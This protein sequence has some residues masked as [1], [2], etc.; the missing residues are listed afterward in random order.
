MK[1]AIRERWLRPR[2]LLFA[3]IGSA[4]GLGNVWRFPYMVYE[5]GAAAFLIAY[6]IGLVV[7]GIP[8]MMMEFGMGRRMQSGAPG[9]F[10][11]I[12]KKWEWV[13]WWPVF[14]AFLI[15][16]YY[17]VIMAWSLHYAAAAT[18]MAWGVGEAGALATGNYFFGEVLRLS[19]G[20]GV[21]GSPIWAIVG[22]LA[23]TWLV[24]C[25]IIYKGASVIGRVSQYLMIIAWASLVI[26]FFRG[27]TLVGAVDGLNFYLAP[28][29]SALLEGG[30][31]F[32]A[33]SQIAFTLSLGMAGMFAYG[34]FIARRGDIANSA[35]ITS[36]ADGATAFFAGFAIFSTAGY[37][38]Y[39]M[40][41]GIEEVALSGLGLAFVAY[42]SMVSMLPVAPAFFG[43][44]FFLMFWF[45]GISSAYFL[46]YGGV[47]TPL[48]DK[49]GWSR[50][51]TAIGVCLAC[52]II[53][54]LYTT[55]GGLYWLDIVDRTVAFYVLLLSGV[56]AAIVV[57]WAYGADKLREHINETSDFKVGAWFEWIIK[58]VLP[59]GL[60]FVVIYGGF[61]PD[62]AAPYEGY[63]LWA[64]SM[65]WVILIV[66]L[67]ISFLLQSLKT[68][69]SMTGSQEEKG[70]VS[71]E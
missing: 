34:S 21:L 13:G 42:P 70:E 35:T 47:V 57:G 61:L 56:I 60:L 44:L 41:I 1:E 7:L 65:I 8:W 38:M 40:G 28:D 2:H 18:T 68:R 46:A 9:V 58:I 62:I 63:P 59:A 54:I 22:L 53:G 25:L 48:V 69:G 45:I 4:I 33:L 67:V 10:A 6:M 17:T 16:T 24:V 30:L 39:A 12:G 29:F 49:F 3:A 31:W 52:F 64:A 50:G 37:L 19:P 71:K 20:P 55:Q 15:C 26:L 14:A 32:G 27:I 51:K 11:G 66:T 43:T 36:F 5:Y 23:L